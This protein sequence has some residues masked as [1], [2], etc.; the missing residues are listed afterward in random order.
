MTKIDAGQRAIE[1]ILSVQRAFRQRRRMIMVAAAG[2]LAAKKQ[3]PC[4]RDFGR[5]LKRS[6]YADLSRHE[7]ASLIAIARNEKQIVKV[8]RANPGLSSPVLIWRRA[9]R[10]MAGEKR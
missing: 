4:T 6:S 10:Q 3:N 1:E 8:L 9:R 7:R 2:L 5:W